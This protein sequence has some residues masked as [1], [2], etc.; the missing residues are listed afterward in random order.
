M[1]NWAKH[2]PNPPAKTTDKSRASK[3]ERRE[4]KVTRWTAAEKILAVE[5]KFE[6]KFEKK[7]PDSHANRRK[8]RRYPPNP[9]AH[10]GPKALAGVD[11]EKRAE[12]VASRKKRR[13]EEREA[14][15]AGGEKRAKGGGE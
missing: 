1:R 13:E 4:G 3:K 2:Q 6:E 15:Q 7:K 5:P 10:W 14:R 12:K 9:E 11:L 8:A